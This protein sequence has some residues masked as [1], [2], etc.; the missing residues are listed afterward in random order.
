M[1]NKL[2][3]KKTEYPVGHMGRQVWLNAGGYAVA[4][5]HPKQWI[6]LV[7]DMWIDKDGFLHLED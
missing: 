6:Y 1:S 4:Q 5:F 7:E 2:K 3:T